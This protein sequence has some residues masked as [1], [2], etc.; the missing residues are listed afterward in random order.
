MSP[1]VATP[2]I[3]DVGLCYAG[4]FSQLMANDKARS[5]FME[6]YNPIGSSAAFSMRSKLLADLKVQYEKALEENWDGD[7]ADAVSW[8]AYANAVAFSK[9]LPLGLPAPDVMAV[10]DGSLGFEWRG[11]NNSIL[12]VSIDDQKN[13]IFAMNANNNLQRNGMQVFEGKAIDDL[14][15]L[16]N[17]YFCA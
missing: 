2:E 7:G 5:G 11:K 3:H 12:A 1:F 10:N 17:K 6:P 16:L 8:E 4:T 15:A 14:E 13:L 9:S